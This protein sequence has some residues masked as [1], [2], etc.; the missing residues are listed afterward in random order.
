M[1]E[2]PNAMLDGNMQKDNPLGFS[3]F[4]P[5]DG[6]RLAAGLKDRRMELI[7]GKEKHSK[8]VNGALDVGGVE[9]GLPQVE[10]VN[11]GMP[12]VMGVTMQR[13]VGY[14]E[15]QL[16]DLLIEV[17]Q[18][19]SRMIDLIHTQ[20]G[21]LDHKAANEGRMAGLEDEHMEFIFG[22]EKHSKSVDGAFDMGGVERGLPQVEGVNVEMPHVMGVTMQQRVGDVEVQLS[23]LLIEVNQIKSRMIDLIHTQNGMCI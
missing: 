2:T 19:K 13:R 22:K 3:D 21:M 15:V 23:D 5:I 17:N 10:G 8:S 12:H 18:I 14:M 1:E 9:G 6:D 11:V 7:F 20:N 16:S 4:T